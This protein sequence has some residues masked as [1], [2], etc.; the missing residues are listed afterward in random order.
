M[1]SDFICIPSVCLIFLLFVNLDDFLA[2]IMF[3]SL[4]GSSSYCKAFILVNQRREL[5]T[6]STKHY[7]CMATTQHVR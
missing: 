2:L 3:G 6:L 7:Y 5:A 4:F 1:F